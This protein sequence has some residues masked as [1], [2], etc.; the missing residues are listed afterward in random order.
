MKLTIKAIVFTCASL[1]TIGSAAQG[2]TLLNVKIGATTLNGGADGVYQEGAAVLGSASSWWNEY[3]YV[4]STP[5]Q[6]SVVDNFDAAIAGVTLTVQNSGGTG[7]KATS[8]TNPGFLFGS[9]P[10][11]NAGGVFTISLTGLSANTQY[12]FI[13]YAARTSSSA[14]ASWAV[15]TGTFDSGTTLNDG[16][17]MDITTGVGK[18]YSDFLATTDGSGNLTITDSGNPGTSITVLA[19]FQ[20]QSVINVP[21]PG[22]GALLLG[23]CG[24][25][26]ACRRFRIS[27]AS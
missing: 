23:G 21:E 26:F 2:Q 22:V 10:Y 15:T 20:L 25:L 17:S 18:S 7:T 8:G 19:G 13:G 12:E 14:G 1:L 9:M 5:Y 27:R 4:S 6:V 11:Q 3:A 24:L 16:T